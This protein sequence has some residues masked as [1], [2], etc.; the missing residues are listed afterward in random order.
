MARQYIRW[1]K[2]IIFYNKLFR[3]LSKPGIALFL[4]ALTPYTLV[5]H[6]L[7]CNIIFGVIFTSCF[8]YF[9]STL[10]YKYLS[11]KEK[12]TINPE[13]PHYKIHILYCGI[14]TDL[15]TSAVKLLRDSLSTAT[16]TTVYT[17]GA[18]VGAA[19]I[20]EEVVVNQNQ[21]QVTE[22]IV[23][24][25]Y[26]QA[27]Y[28]RERLLPDTA[29]H[30]ENVAIWTEASNDIRLPG[31]VLA[32]NLDGIL[33]LEVNADHQRC[34][35]ESLRNTAA[36]AEAEQREEQR[37]QEHQTDF[38]R[39]ELERESEMR[40]RSQQ[41]EARREEWENQ[42]FLERAHSHVQQLANIVNLVPGG[43]EVTSSTVH[44]I[45]DNIIGRVELGVDTIFH[46]HEKDPL[47]PTSSDLPNGLYDPRTKKY[48]TLPFDEDSKTDPSFIDNDDNDEER[49]PALHI[50]PLTNPVSVLSPLSHAD[51]LTPENL[52][53]LDL[54]L[55]ELSE[56]KK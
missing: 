43:N 17:T 10:F 21:N 49:I 2:I 44:R 5:H 20:A 30:Y 9:M 55:A 33:Q 13:N 39:R 19:I 50:L 14:K 48:I 32:Q 35:E 16:M 37:R 22:M 1:H 27:A 56:N 6:S 26:R 24:H 53:E 41:R 3:F 12:K 51:P 36:L 8:T 28:F 42:S 45:S 23:D 40:D 54:I 4:G 29:L 46:F 38:L 11:D 34:R 15:A 7:G 31:G 47:F 25:H 18:V 52:A